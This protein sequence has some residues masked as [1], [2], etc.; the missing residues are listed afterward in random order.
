M[1]LRK[2]LVASAGA[3]VLIASTAIAGAAQTAPSDATDVDI[4]VTSQGVLSVSVE[5]VNAFD[6]IQYSFQDQTVNGTL[7]VTVTDERGTAEGWS[8]N[9]RAE[10]FTGTAGGPGDSFPV[11]GLGLSFG[12]TS[13]VTG[14][15]D[16]TGISGFGVGSVSST[17]QRIADASN[18]YGNG[19]YRLLYPGEL[20]IPGDTLVDTYT[21]TVTVEAVSA[22]E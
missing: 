3:A 9:L 17:G 7:R 21:S 19:Q 1:H 14:N 2:S 18:G 16:T 11:S 20:D 5:E 8:F 22:P 15:P 4:E 13:V 12:G 10:D 6:D